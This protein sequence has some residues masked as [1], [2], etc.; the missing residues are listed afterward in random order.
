MIWGFV[1]VG[2]TPSPCGKPVVATLL[3]PAQALARE[4]GM[5]DSEALHEAVK[6]ADLETIRN[7]LS[8]GHSPNALDAVGLPPLAYL[9]DHVDYIGFV[10]SEP[11]VAMIRL[12]RAAGAYPPSERAKRRVMDDAWRCV[13]SAS[14][15]NDA[16]MLD[17]LLDFEP[18]D[19]RFPAQTQDHAGEAL[20]VVLPGQPGDRSHAAESVSTSGQARIVFMPMDMRRRIFVGAA[21]SL[22]ALACL[23]LGLRAVDALFEGRASND[24]LVLAVA[25]ACFGVAWWFIRS[26]GRKTLAQ[27]KRISAETGLTA[28]AHGG[29]G[30]INAGSLEGAGPRGRIRA[31]SSPAA[32]GGNPFTRIEIAGS[33]SL[34]DLA[35]W[36]ARDLSSHKLNCLSVSLV[37]GQV[38]RVEVSGVIAQPH[39]ADFIIR[40]AKRMNGDS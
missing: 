37:P 6:R 19:G 11:M 31:A 30:L 40:L 14:E 23:V 34:H 36:I 12:L 21:L 25:L 5:V 26:S 39:V 38:Y 35:A 15:A 20:P 13:T 24:P 9:M 16:R 32:T 8:A 4:A 18:V 10:L 1:A 17:G 22:V 2:G 33:D 27:L 3:G 7:L 28:T 29:F